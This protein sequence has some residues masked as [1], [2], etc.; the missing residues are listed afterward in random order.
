M[1]LCDPEKREI[2][3]PELPNNKSWRR[4][5]G[6]FEELTWA[7]SASPLSP[8]KAFAAWPVRGWELPEAV[9]H[10]SFSSDPDVLDEYGME[11]D[12]WRLSHYA[13][14][15]YRPV[16]DFSGVVLD[17]PGP[18]PAQ[19]IALVTA[20]KLRG[21]LIDP[22]DPDINLPDTASGPYAGVDWHPSRT[23]IIAEPFG[24]AVVLTA[25]RLAA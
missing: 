21:H 6:F 14:G 13:Q 7:T 8:R 18:R 15:L 24:H 22:D 20:L 19:E 3:V 9:V 11:G 2:K 12:R 17:L 10:Y 1:Q 4:L 5:K 25:D 23:T 16:L